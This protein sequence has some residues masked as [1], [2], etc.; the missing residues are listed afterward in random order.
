MDSDGSGSTGKGKDKA[1][2]SGGPSDDSSSVDLRETVAGLVRQ[3]MEA[4]RRA[5]AERPAVT[6]VGRRLARKGAWQR[7]RTPVQ[8]SRRGGLFRIFSQGWLR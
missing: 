1:P 8:V 6:E 4:E 7:P 2:A 5:S 3:A